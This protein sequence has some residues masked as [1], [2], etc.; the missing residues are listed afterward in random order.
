MSVPT[1]PPLDDFEAVYTERL[2]S[3]VPAIYKQADALTENAGTLRAIV[4]VVA[5]RAAELRRS[6]DRLGEDPFAEVCD[7]WA[8]PYLADLVGTRLVSALNE[9][10]RRVD[11]AKTIYY[12]RRK[13]TPRVLEELVADITGWEGTVVEMFRRLPRHRHGLD[14]PYGPR[15]GRF[16]GTLPGGWANLRSVRGG[17]QAGGPFDEYHHTPDVRR[18]EGTH[19]RHGI[20]KLG[21]HLYRLPAWRLDRV[22]PSDGIDAAT[23]TIDP[24]GRSLQLFMR[25]VRPDDWEE[26]RRPLPWEVPAPMPCRLLGHEVY[27]ITEALVATLDAIPPGL[28]A[29][30]T[31]EIRSLVGHRLQGRTGLRRAL[32]G[33]STG[34]TF[35]APGLFVPLVAGALADDCGHAALLPE[36][37][38]IESAPGTTIEPSRIAAG[39]LPGAAWPTL[40]TAA[41]TRV[42]V[43][44]EQGRL[45]FLGG[46]PAAELTLSFHYG[47]PGP[48]GAGPWPRSAGLADETFLLLGGGT[49][50]AGAIAPDDVTQIEDNGTYETGAAVT[51]ITDAVLQSA[52]GTRPYLQLTADWVL[53][54]GANK[55]ST[56]VVDGLW[57]GGD[58]TRVI[59]LRGDFEH[60][61]L[62]T[63]TVDPGGTKTTGATIAPVAIVVEGAVERL[64]LDHSITGPIRLGANG[65]VEE[66]VLNDSVVHA[67]LQA[68]ALPLTEMSATR[69][70]VLGR[71][72]V[73]RLRS[74]DSIFTGVVDVTDSQ[75]GCFRFSAALAGS[76][77][78]HPYESF[79]LDPARVTSLFTSSVFG[80][81]AYLQ[82]SE[83]ATPEVARGAE[84]G[85]D[86][87]VWSALLGPI[88]RDGLRAK[89]DEFAPFGLIPFY[90]FET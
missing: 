57:I 60:V 36:A 70:T 81:F 51:P 48:V 76:H 83:A 86:M 80:H 79:I 28:N 72:D 75:Y 52:D 29:T 44:A 8:L 71:V 63:V 3:L 20:R 37:L 35:L 61:L 41:D 73:D 23:R 19:G 27:V 25:R 2:W 50:G 53:D 39:S 84:S 64:E 56:L 6:V 47:W 88:K 34:A 42:V 10:G 30:Q 62:R 31:R 15:A 58:G 26:W 32:N 85:S 18:A 38:R 5:S 67:D 74:T 46:A 4:E 69:S 54:S 55:D 11:V 49:L 14:P 7:P 9:R 87:G 17:E 13:G 66:L 21:I 82:L 40:A 78:P 24:S 68:V 45:R 59:R 16:S 43:D 90:V 1:R 89:V 77:L 65:S 12:R 22:E 33:L